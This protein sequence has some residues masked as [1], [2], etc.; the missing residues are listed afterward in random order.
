MMKE[1]PET[2]ENSPE[3]EA[4][5]RI[6]TPK[7]SYG[8]WIAGFLFAVSTYFFWIRPFFVGKQ[9]VKVEFENS[10]PIAAPEVS[11]EGR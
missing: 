10:V 6:S 4:K 8:P 3:L 1:P 7:V 11:V 2:L 5:P 9:P